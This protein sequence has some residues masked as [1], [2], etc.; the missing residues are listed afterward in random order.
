MHHFLYPSKDTYISSRNGY[1]EKNFGVDEILQIGTSNVIVRTLET[2]KAYA[3]NAAIFN[4]YTVTSFT[5]T[6]TGSFD[7]FVTFLSGSLTGSNMLTASYFS[8]SI[9]GAP[10]AIYNSNI[11]G[12]LD[13]ALTG[14]I[15]SSLFIGEFT[16]ILSGSNGCL[17]GTSSGVDTR[18]E[19][20]WKSTDTKF[21]DRS[22]L[23][24]NLDAISSSISSGAITNPQFRLKM[25]VCNE[26]DLPITYN[27]HALP[28]S[29]SW[30]MG[31]GYFSDGGSTTGISW[32]NRDFKDGT[33][34]WDTYT[35]SVRPAID[36]ISN[37]ASATGSFEYGGGTW[38]TSSVSSSQQFEY[39]SS[40]INMDVT[41]I[42]MSWISGSLPNQGL[43]LLS[44]DELQSTGSGFVLKFFSK[45]TNSI[46]SPYLDVMWLGNNNAGI[47]GSNYFTGSLITSSVVISTI[48]SGMTVTVQSG[49]TFS[50]TN[51]VSGSFTGSSYLLP[52][53]GNETYISMSGIV[54]GH[55]VGGNILNVP[56]VG[57]YSGYITAVTQSVSGTCG[58][59]IHTNFIT[60]S[61]LNGVF[62]GSTFTAYY[63]NNLIE[64]AVLTGSWLT[65]SLLG[66]SVSI[67]SLPSGIDPYAYA[68]I[69]GVYMNGRAFGTYA[70]SGSN[71]DGGGS[72]SGSF[73]GQFI[74][75]ALLGG[76]LNLQLSGSVYTSSYQYTSS[77]SYSSTA[78]TA[79]NTLNPFVVAA[80]NVRPVYKVGDIAKIGV[81]GRKQFPLKT[82]GLSTQQEQYVTPEYL[83]S[84]SF[85]ALKDN[86]T[87]EIILDFD[88]FTK[89]GCEY[90][91]GNFFVID[92][93]GLPQERYYRVL[94]RVEDNGLV[95]TIDCGKT[96]KITR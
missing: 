61:F 27:I 83:P 38:Y 78:L 70:I 36:F 13:G 25:K 94:V 53:T 74:D 34:W 43:L 89:L 24:F 66:A 16:G 86:E 21:I 84:S 23:Q 48:N 20:N 75:G 40:D 92:T 87:G 45:D 85:Y 46:Y 8:G 9:D 59:I 72:N 42:V 30:N 81:F 12:S 47:S 10:I 80:N 19:Q 54:D 88:A 31:N 22:L 7:G 57:A 63:M 62:S 1:A 5:G 6:F 15:T 32:K 33:L 58:N 37:P 35:S 65:S 95:H 60:A 3:Y 28:V 17:N 71:A 49:S 14:S 77:V 50:I 91:S 93:T 39:E 18:N 55:G 79:L 44:S 11:S 2:T 52:T 56:V 26:Y 41:P 90:P 82:F 29:Q 67:A 76:Y 73:V 64:N 68:N 51:G 69:S 96:F 4:Y